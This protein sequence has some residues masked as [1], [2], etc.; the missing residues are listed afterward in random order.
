MRP[1]A[2][3]LSTDLATSHESLRVETGHAAWCRNVGQA[4]GTCTR[5][6]EHVGN[7]GRKE[8][9]PPCQKPAPS[10]ARAPK[11]PCG[12]CGTWPQA[13]RTRHARRSAGSS[14]PARRHGTRSGVCFLSRLSPIRVDSSSASYLAGYLRDNKPL[15]DISLERMHAA[16]RGATKPCQRKL[17]PRFASALFC[18]ARRH[19]WLVQM[20]R[21]PRPP[22][23]SRARGRSLSSVRA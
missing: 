23:A 7:S 4:P 10:G 15:P 3:H 14:R 1:G 2:T 16:P 11:A 20:P 17:A 22:A 6:G 5:A 21:R 13:G 19:G 12:H 9:D 8:A 18:S